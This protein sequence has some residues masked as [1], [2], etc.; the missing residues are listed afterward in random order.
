MNSISVI[1]ATYNEEKNILRCLK[2]V[3]WADEIVIV[4][5]TSTDKTVEL[6][7]KYTKNIIVKDNPPMFHLNKQLAIEKAKGDW[8]LYLDADEEISDELKNEILNTVKETKFN[9]YWIPRKNIIFGKWIEY[10]GWYP[11]YQLRLFR[12]GKGRLPCKSLHEQP[13]VEGETAKLENALVHYN[14]NNVDQYLHKLVNIYTTN[15]KETKKKENIKADLKEA[16]RFPVSEFLKRYYLEK[17]YKDNL[18]GLVLSM[19]QSFS[20]FI[21]YAKIWEEQGF[22]G[23]Q[24]ASFLNEVETEFARVAKEFRYW[25][26]T[27][28][29]NDSPGVL[30][31]F[32]YRLRRKFSL[33]L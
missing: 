19:F 12:N 4:D 22:P 2:S 28:K 32:W 11:D 10:T 13:E 3:L 23:A 9:G 21:T 30:K 16:I 8:I 24:S 20:A 1:L 27:T 6:A 25:S 18:H 33:V 15:D 26:L 31:K 14:Y 7:K 5:G 17:G 29:I